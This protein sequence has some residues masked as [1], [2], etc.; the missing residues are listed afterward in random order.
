M[1]PDVDFDA[2]MRA[3]EKELSGNPQ[4]TRTEPKGGKTTAPRTPQPAKAKA[5]D[6]PGEDPLEQELEDAEA[7]AAAA[8]LKVADPAPEEPAP[9][10]AGEN[11]AHTPEASEHEDEDA[12]SDGSDYEKWKK[13]LSK[14]AQ[15]Q[16]TRQEFEISNLKKSATERFNIAPQAD[17]PL[18]HVST[19]EDLQQEQKHWTTVRDA[20]H[21]LLT[22]LAS[23][24][25]TPMEITLSDGRK[26]T[27]PDA[28]SVKYNH[29]LSHQ[30]LNAVPDAKQRLMDR[31]AQKPWEAA[32]KLAPEL[33]EK[34]SDAVKQAVD[35]L[36]KNPQFKSAFPDWEV[37]LAHMFRS[38][39]QEQEEKSGKA[40]HVRLE[41]DGDGNVKM[42]RKAVARQ[43][44]AAPAP[45]TPTTPAVN[46]PHLNGSGNGD[47][48]KSKIAALEKS[49]SDDDLRAA[50]AEL[51]A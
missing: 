40:R 26:H 23:D 28:A 33:F 39:K 47:R 35:F 20:T 36:R 37:K 45:R 3:L 18:A 27:F 24:P 12:P 42:P 15:R 10:A 11:Q 14:G 7:A 8:K 32:S 34:D 41:L 51:V 17:S 49:G 9:K 38:M 48:L 29:D 5:I 31:D 4:D 43:D 19:Q 50:V 2:E 46:R 6:T 25:D 44:T 1:V 22:D 30:T 21:K 16:L 13:T